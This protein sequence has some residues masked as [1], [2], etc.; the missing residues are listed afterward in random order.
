MDG[1]FQCSQKAEKEGEIRRGVP[2]FSEGNHEIQVVA[3]DRFL[4]KTIIKP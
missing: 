4:N 1:M 2:V 3:Y